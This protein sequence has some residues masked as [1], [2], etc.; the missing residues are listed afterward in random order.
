MDAAAVQDCNAWNIKETPGTPVSKELTDT[1]QRVREAGLNGV[2]Q[3]VDQLLAAAG[4]TATKKDTGS[5][6]ESE[7]GW[8]S[9]CDG[10][11]VTAT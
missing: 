9:R 4:R 1:E 10:W 3:S 5:S 8:R 11:W 6:P 7:T 2:R